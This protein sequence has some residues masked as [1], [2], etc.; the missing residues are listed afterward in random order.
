MRM[1]DAGRECWFVAQVMPGEERV[2]VAEMQRLAIGMKS[3]FAPT[4]LTAGGR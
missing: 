3:I 1:F 4:C 2:A